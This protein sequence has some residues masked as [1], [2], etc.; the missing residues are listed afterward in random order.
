M[1]DTHR[2]DE[3]VLKEVG[4]SVAVARPGPHV[5][6]MVLRCDT[7]FTQVIHHAQSEIICTLQLPLSPAT[8]KQTTKKKKMRKRE[9]IQGNKLRKKLLPKQ[10]FANLF[11]CVMGKRRP[12]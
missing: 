6:L 1:C 7:R 5:V 3:D 4:K 2:D 12:V 8:N 11:F 10:N 9:N